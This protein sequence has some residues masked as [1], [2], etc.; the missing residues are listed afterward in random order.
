MAGKKCQECGKTNPH[1]FTHCVDCGAKLETDT[2]KTGK[3]LRYL[4]IGLVLCVS[5]ILIIFVILPALRYSQTF[6]QNFSETVAAKSAAESQIIPEYS[7]N[8]PVENNGLQITIISA[9]DGQN[10]YN[11]NKFFITSVY[12]KNNRTEGNIHVFSS[13]FE[14]IDSEGSTYFPYGIGS[15]MM[16]DLSPSQSGSGELTYVI[17]QKVTGQKIQVTFPQST[18]FTGSSNIAIFRI[19]NT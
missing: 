16:Y 9:R 4:K 11:S 10:T 1:F 13:N 17:P 5:V 6:G 7:L 18:G 12:L 15:K 14:L 19:G 8:R 2:Q 3:T